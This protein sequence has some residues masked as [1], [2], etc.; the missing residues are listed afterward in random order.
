[1]ESISRH[2]SAL[3]TQYG[4]GKPTHPLI[5][6]EEDKPAFLMEVLQIEA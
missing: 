3:N 2:H 6:E 1:M 4:V 5:A